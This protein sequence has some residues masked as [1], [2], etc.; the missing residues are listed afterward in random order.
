[1]RDGND[2]PYQVTFVWTQVASCT[3]MQL[4]ASRLTVNCRGKMAAILKKNKAWLFDLMRSNLLQI[5]P[6]L[7]TE[8]IISIETKEAALRED[9]DA[10]FRANRLFS[11]IENEIKQQD[12]PCSF[13]IKFLEVLKNSNIGRVEDLEK[14]I[15]EFRE[16]QRRASR[17]SSAA[18]TLGSLDSSSSSIFIKLH[19]DDERESREQKQG[20]TER[21]ENVRRVRHHSESNGSI[22]S[23]HKPLTH[24]VS[25]PSMSGHL[26]QRGKRLSAPSYSDNAEVEEGGLG[27]CTSTFIPVQTHEEL[28][29][30]TGAHA[31]QLGTIPENPNSPYVFTFPLPEHTSSQF[32]VNSG[33]VEEGS[34]P[35]ATAGAVL[36]DTDVQMMDECQFDIEEHSRM[37]DFIHSACYAEGTSDREAVREKYEKMLKFYQEKIQKADATHSKETMH[38]RSAVEHHRKCSEE[39]EHEV[40]G[41]NRQL[42]ELKHQ[43]EDGKLKLADK[44]KEVYDLRK[45]VI[46]LEHRVK[47]N[48]LKIEVLRGDKLYHSKLTTMVSNSGAV[49]KEKLNE[50]KKMRELVEELFQGRD[51]TKI[52]LAILKKANSVK[53]IDRPYTN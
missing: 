12:E 6:S 25:D 2:K 39:K 18:S 51:I 35:V 49:V 7:C 19:G 52:K 34:M 42:E 23:P 45:Q 15:E 11:D 53:G 26:V 21:Q 27:M 16:E 38:L 17:R 41:K 33:D 4:V 5:V 22:P 14:T 20:S 10:Q 40:A 37:E 36:L 29:Q 31:L 28:F 44:E 46:L 48:Q 3:Y 50:W 8:K 47:E 9:G 13:G 32:A 43:L 30:Q 1:M 24:S